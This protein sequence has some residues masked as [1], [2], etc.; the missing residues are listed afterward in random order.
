MVDGGSE[1]PG[2]YSVLL[3]FIFCST[4]LVPVSAHS[5]CILGLPRKQNLFCLLKMYAPVGNV[6]MEEKFSLIVCYQHMACCYTMT[7]WP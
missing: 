4:E 2:A 6:I 5:F 3:Y 1:I 7:H